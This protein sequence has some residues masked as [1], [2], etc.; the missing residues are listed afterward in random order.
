MQVV[1]LLESSQIKQ[2]NVSRKIKLKFAILYYV[3]T[4]GSLRNFLY[5]KFGKKGHPQSV[6]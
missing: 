6:L 3:D 4:G 2:I 5:F 1:K